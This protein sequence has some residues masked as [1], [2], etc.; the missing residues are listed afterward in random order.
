MTPDFETAMKYLKDK[1]DDAKVMNDFGNTIRNIVH[2]DNA[3]PEEV[4][5]YIIDVLD[6][7]ND[8]V[9]ATNAALDMFSAITGW[10]FE[11]IIG[12]LIVNEQYRN[13]VHENVS[14]YY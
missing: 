8:N 5:R 12:H 6:H 2:D 4:G 11:Q 13:H 14:N 10:Q 3:E 1:H 9:Y 7:F